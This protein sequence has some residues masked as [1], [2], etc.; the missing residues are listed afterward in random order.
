[1]RRK[2]QLTVAPRAFRSDDHDRIQVVDRVGRI[3]GCFHFEAPEISVREIG[4]RTGL[5]KSTAHEILIAL[6]YNGLIHQNPESGSYRLGGVY[7]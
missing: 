7:G 3:L 2:S 6:Q 4:D 1:M 5:H